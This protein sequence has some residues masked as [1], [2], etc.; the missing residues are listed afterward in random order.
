[1]GEH[2]MTQAMH[3]RDIL[4]PRALAE[5]FDWPNGRRTLLEELT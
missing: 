5:R 3:L 2:H 4:T 1:M